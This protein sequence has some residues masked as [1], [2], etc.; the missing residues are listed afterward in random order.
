MT[1]P[2]TGTFFE[3]EHHNRAEGKFYN[4]AMFAFSEEQWRAKVRE[5]AELGMDTLV[6]LA[7]ALRE[8]SYYP[9]KI[10]PYAEYLAC[11]NVLEVLLDEADKTGQR[12][13]LS[14]GFYG[15]WLDR[16]DQIDHEAIG[17]S[18]Q[19]MN[20]ISGQYGHHP[21]IEGWYL[22]DEWCI[23]EEFDPRFIDY[24]NLIS[25]EARRLNPKNKTIIAPYGTRLVKFNDNYVRQLEQLDLDIIAYQDEVGVQKT[26]VDEEAAFYEN[27]RRVHDKAGRAALWADMETFCFEGQVYKSGLL[28]APWERVKAQM[29]A[30]SPF[31][32]KLIIYSY[33]G[34]MTK[35]GGIAHAGQEGTAEQLY[36]DYKAWLDATT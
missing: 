5:T 20:E 11:P 29:E 15:C 3:F 30:I 34:M 12:V 8:R 19:A 21:C 14:V 4:E 32:D 10:H 36:S 35:P 7:T 16:Y 13:F 6:L 27:L 2:I 1:K 25:A 31:V 23:R 17:R 18:L 9:S 26:R 22:P 33:Q 28:P 24:V